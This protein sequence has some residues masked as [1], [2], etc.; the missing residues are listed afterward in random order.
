MRTNINSPA[1][2]LPNN[3]IPIEKVLATNS[4]IF[5]PR[6]KTHNAGCEPKGAQSNSL[7]KPNKTLYFYTVEHHQE[8]IHPKQG[9]LSR[10][11]R[12]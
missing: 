9:P 11:N 7:Q 8:Q 2:I 6:L 10:L 12:P 4:I 3:L 1:Y 5:N